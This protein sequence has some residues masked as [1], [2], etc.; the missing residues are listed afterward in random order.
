MPESPDR[1]IDLKAIDH[2]A[3]WEGTKGSS[4]RTFATVCFIR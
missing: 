2:G 3:M 4:S 1:M